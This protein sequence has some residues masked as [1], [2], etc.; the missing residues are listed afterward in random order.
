M[1]S[2][3]LELSMTDITRYPLLNPLMHFIRYACN[4][5][6]PNASLNAMDGI[7]P[8]E[9]CHDEIFNSDSSAR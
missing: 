1:K 4:A 2:D 6:N 3:C 9:S 7:T 8:K 5:C